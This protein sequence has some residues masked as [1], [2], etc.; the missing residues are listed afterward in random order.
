MTFHCSAG[1]KIHNENLLLLLKKKKMQLIRVIES[2]TYYSVRAIL[3][4]GASEGGICHPQWHV[5]EVWT[6]ASVTAKTMHVFACHTCVY[7]QPA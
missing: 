1:K 7:T 5:A 6:A 2:C 4:D 3:L